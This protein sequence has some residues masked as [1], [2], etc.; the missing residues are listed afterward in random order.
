MR[1]GAGLEFTTGV[2]LDWRFDAWSFQPLGHLTD[3]T[4]AAVQPV[5]IEDTRPAEAAPE[6]VGGNVTVGSFNV[7]NYFTTLGQDVA[8]CSAYRDRAGNPVTTNGCL[9]RGAYTSEAF[10]RQ[11]EKIAAAIN[12]L[13]TSVVALEE[14]ENSEKFG[15]DRDHALAHLV[16]ALNAQA[17]EQRWAYV[18]SPATRPAL[19]DEDVI[20]SA[21]IYQPAEVTP[22]GES[23]ILDDQTNFDNAREPMA[24]LFRAAD[25]T[26]EGAAG[27]D[28]VAI[29]NHFKSKGGSGATG[30]NVDAGDG[31][32]AYNA[33]RVGQA[34]ALVAFAERMKAET[35]TDRVLLMGDF[36]AYEKED[37]IRVLEAAGYVSQG[38]LTGEYSYAFG[39]AVGSLD[40]I[41][42]S[43]SAATAI[44]GQDIWMINANESVALEYSRHNY[45][46]EDLYSADQ[47]RSSDHNP[48]LV[49]LQLDAPVTEPTPEPEPSPGETCDGVTDPRGVP[50]KPAN[51]V[52]E[53]LRCV[54][55]TPGHGGDHPGKG[56][57]PEHPG[58]GRGPVRP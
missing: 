48:I 31:Q 40:G 21:F 25:G 38:A 49:G 28:F 27:T 35:G 46:A 33:D 22:V 20:R 13:G 52:R 47:W 50:G 54:G 55:A 3:A 18:A 45:V 11:Q 26:S 42:A 9:P 44:T 43:P 10:A 36:N 24:Q 6:A 53:W 7:L 57:G 30:D 17:G 37:P 51:S 23:V 58:K 32:G 16:E 39:G 15:L 34:E 41:Y 12:G 8:G 56:H 1:V 19:A 14:I 29:T 4:A 5:T 2:I